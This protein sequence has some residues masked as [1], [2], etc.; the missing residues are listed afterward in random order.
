LREKQA[1]IHQSHCLLFETIFRNAGASIPAIGYAVESA[2]APFKLFNFQRRTPGPNDV[3]IRIHYCG[4]CHT[5]IHLTHNDWQFSKYPMVPGHEITGVVEQVGSSVKHL[6]VGDHVGVG[7][8]V[9]S[10]SNCKLCM[11]FSHIYSSF[12]LIQSYR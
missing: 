8:M 7:C 10:C 4:I 2:T 5:D 1:L 12:S 3:L 11:L 9:D 6:H